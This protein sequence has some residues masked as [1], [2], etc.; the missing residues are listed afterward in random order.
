MITISVT[1]LS[2]G[3]GGLYDG[4][5]MDCGIRQGCPLS[6]LLFAA[7]VD[8]LLKIIIKR[9]PKSTSRAF[10][11]DIGAIFECWHEARPIAEDIFNQFAA[12]SGL[13]LNIAKTVCIPLWEGSPEGEVRRALQASDS[14]WKDVCVADHGAYLG[15]NVGPGR[16]SHSSWSKANDKFYK[17]C[18]QWGV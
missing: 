17:R 3:G 9:I 6:P 7:A 5:Q 12:M 1:Y 10:A 4:F 14:S 2:G 13:E 8:V 15:F 18:S 11:D 16:V